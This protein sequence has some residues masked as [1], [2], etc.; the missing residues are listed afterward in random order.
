MQDSHPYLFYEIKV[1]AWFL[2]K[3]YA[4]LLTV[5]CLGANRVLYINANKLDMPNFGSLLD[6]ACNPDVMNWHTT[7]FPCQIV[8][9]ISGTIVTDPF[10][11]FLCP[12][13]S[14]DEESLTSLEIWLYAAF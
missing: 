12:S 6:I 11:P 8:F 2:L 7:L 5:W 13:V 1:F 3:L 4:R 9:K 10:S 14:V